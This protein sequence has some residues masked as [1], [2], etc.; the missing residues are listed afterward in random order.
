[1]PR[2]LAKVLKRIHKLAAAGDVRVTYKAGREGLM[3]GL[4]PEDVLDVDLN[5]CEPLANGFRYSDGLPLFKSRMTTLP[6][7]HW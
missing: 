6:I 5:I 2:W 3:L 1:M 7:G 4:S